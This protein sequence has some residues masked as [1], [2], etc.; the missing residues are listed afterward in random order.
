MGADS[1]QRTRHWLFALITLGLTA[2]VLELSATFFAR[3]YL[4]Y[5][6]PAYGNFLMDHAVLHHAWIP[7]RLTTIDD[8]GV[9]F[10][11]CTNSQGWPEADDVGRKKPAGVFRVFYVGDSNTQGVVMP[12]FK[13]VELVKKGL[14]ARYRGSPV[15]FEVINTGTSSYS[16]LLYHLLVKTVL[17]DYSPDLVVLD[18]DMSD[19][20]DDAGYRAHAVRDTPK[21]GLAPSAVEAGRRLDTQAGGHQPAI[22]REDDIAALPAQR[23]G[24]ERTGFECARNPH[25]DR[26]IHRPQRDQCPAIGRQGE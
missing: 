9:P 4:L 18:I 11:L 10:T 21:P 1:S 20:P 12:E 19:V 26:A 3:K 23:K 17:P 25:L 2:T 5:T 8:R 24:L 7:N 22:R 15:R 6:R 13:M 16:L 14:N